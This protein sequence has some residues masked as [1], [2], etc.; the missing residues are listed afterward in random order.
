MPCLG[1]SS[2]VLGLFWWPIYREYIFKL[3][4]KVWSVAV[5]WKK[6]L[7]EAWEGGKWKKEEVWHGGEG[8]E[9]ER[10]ETMGSFILFFQSNKRHTLKQQVWELLFSYVEPQRS[11]QGWS[12]EMQDFNADSI[13]Y[14]RLCDTWTWMLPHFMA[15][16]SHFCKVSM[17]TQN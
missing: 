4:A 11:L 8:A 5:P 13:N 3:S 14:Y 2:Y 17:T 1:S 6:Q 15:R 16:Q 9:K 7:K 12:L 10:K